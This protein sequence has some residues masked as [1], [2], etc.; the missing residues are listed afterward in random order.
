MICSACGTANP[1]GMRYCGMC[2]VPLDRQ[3]GAA[4]ERR[5]VT[6]LFV[7]LSGFSGL[8]RD[9]DPEDLRDLADEVLTVVTG[10]VE[11][12]DGYVDALKGDGLLALFG[13]PH[14]HP[15]DALRAV[16]AGAASLRAIEDIGKSR[17]LPLKGRAG[18]N[19]GIVIAG[20]VGSGRVRS[21]TVM[22]SAVNLA[23][24]LEE[25][26][27]PGDVW[28]GPETHQATRHRI[29]YQPTGPISLHGF[30]DITSAHRLVMPKQQQTD[31]YAHVPF[32]G[33]ANELEL[34]RSA[35]DEAV[36][37]ETA[38][39]A[40]LVGEAGRGKTRLVREFVKRLGGRPLVLWLEQPVT[41]EAAFAGLGRQLF[42]LHLAE[43]PRSAAPRV[44]RLLHG[45]LPGEPR[46]HQL[47]LES[48]DLAQRSTWTRI[49][50]RSIDRTNLAWRDLLVA[51]TRR[52]PGTE[53]G[54][55][56]P[57]VLIV[58]NEPNDPAS[59]EFVA[60][61]A[62]AEAPMLVLRT[63]RRHAVDHA[64]V[65]HLPAL[66]P[67]ES[68]RLLGEV[69]GPALRVAAAGLVEQVGGVPAFV[70]ELGRAL[71][72][73]S[74]DSFPGSLASL[75][76]ARID[77]IDAPYRRLLAHAALAG[78]VVWEGLLR[79]LAGPAV[80][81]DVEVLLREKMLVAQTGSS[82]PDELEYRFQSEFLRNGLLRMIPFSE[83]P[84]LHLRIATWLERH[85]PLSFSAMTA[86]HFSL[87]GAPDAAYAHYL[88][89]ADLATA[90]DDSARAFELF[91]RL[92][93]LPIPPEL[94][95]EGALALTQAALSLG[96]GERARS[97]F[98]RAESLLDGCAPEARRELG[99]VLEQLG[100]DLALLT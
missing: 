51:L 57:L 77:L 25:A 47:I 20:A 89:A 82:I 41:E 84:V 100:H 87:G 83:R 79:E 65:I 8:T 19:T 92:L 30:P 62:A 86:E 49:E 94:R 98:E 16:L 17:G 74:L 80:S 81:G 38:R 14:S 12:Y 7:D 42:A 75:L 67:E 71:S 85:A 21:Y 96:A 50:R 3:A 70:L 91:E 32:I 54:Q 18:V 93:G 26:A 5:R 11:T 40:W 28:V 27:A 90:Q 22:G 24:R 66:T 88:T 36:A 29:H 58:E 53:H 34:L 60:L 73:A 35:Y 56:R 46:W 33:R 48:L 4:R 39:E 55:V 52:G 43:D 64:K 61:V 99:R 95:T 15:D 97:A 23:A 72:V 37:N 78:E 68:L 31:P 9:L 13:A 45:L 1:T 6:M 69:A 63:S 10:V 44:Q 2:G 59:R 76:Q